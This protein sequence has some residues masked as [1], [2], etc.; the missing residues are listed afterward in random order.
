MPPNR[1]DH[2]GPAFIERVEGGYIMCC[3]LCQKV[4]PLRTTPEAARKAL[5]VLGARDGSWQEGPA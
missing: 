1:C 3:I 5:L 2:K 4:G